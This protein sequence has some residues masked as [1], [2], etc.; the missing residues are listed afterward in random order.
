MDTPSFSLGPFLSP[1]ESPLCCGHP[2]LNLAGLEKQEKR[3]AETSLSLV[4]RYRF[5]GSQIVP[6]SQQLIVVLNGFGP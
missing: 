6:L 3:T 5:F 2:D 4:R 1:V